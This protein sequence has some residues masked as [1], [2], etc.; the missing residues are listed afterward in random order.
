[1]LDQIRKCNNKKRRP[2]QLLRLSFLPPC[3]FWEWCNT[4]CSGSR[5]QPAP[6]L[7]ARRPCSK[8]VIGIVNLSPPS[9]PAAQRAKTYC[10]PKTCAVLVLLNRAGLPALLCPLPVTSP[11]SAPPHHTFTK[12]TS[13]P[14]AVRD[15]LRAL[16]ALTHS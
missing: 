3:T 11:P 9:H 5:I 13:S 15:Q 10:S 8:A 1:M 14:W 7:P 4:G 6:S 16:I 2:D 12:P